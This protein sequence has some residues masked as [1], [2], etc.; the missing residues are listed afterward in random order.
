MAEVGGF[1]TPFRMTV[2]GCVCTL[3]GMEIAVWL[4]DCFRIAAVVGFTHGVVGVA[5][6]GARIWRGSLGG[7]G[8]HGTAGGIVTEIAD[9][10]VDSGAEI[11]AVCVSADQ[12]RALCCGEGPAPEGENHV[13][14]SGSA[15][16][17]QGLQGGEFHGA[18]CSL[19]IRGEY[20]RDSAPFLFFDIRIQI[21]QRA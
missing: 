9:E 5:V 3:P 6:T 8:E 11:D 4:S 14:Q 16:A 15:R 13:W 12:V 2:I 7:R 17:E 10:G 19:P 21:H 20:F 18:E 1:F